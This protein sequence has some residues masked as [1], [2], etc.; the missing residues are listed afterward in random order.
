MIWV[1]LDGTHMHSFF[2]YFTH[3]FITCKQTCLVLDLTLVLVQ[4]CSA[5]W[6]GRSCLGPIGETFAMKR[7]AELGFAATGAGGGGEPQAFL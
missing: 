4:T 5:H 7:F 6:T 1:E 3:N 2:F